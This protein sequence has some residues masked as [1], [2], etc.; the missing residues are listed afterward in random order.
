[1]F[2]FFFNFFLIFFLSSC[3]PM[4]CLFQR[5]SPSFH[6]STSASLPFR[7]S[8]MHFP[9]QSTVCHPRYMFAPFVSSPLHPRCYVLNLTLIPYPVVFHS[10]PFCFIYDSSQCFNFSHLQHLRSFH[11]VLRVLAS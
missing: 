3:R 11:L 10:I 7:H 9:Y 5:V 6:R 1:M 2:L 8:V 4:A